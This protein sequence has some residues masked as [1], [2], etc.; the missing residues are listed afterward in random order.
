M[1]TM[2]ADAECMAGWL[3]CLMTVWTAMQ[4][5]IYLTRQHAD[6]LQQTFPSL[7]FLAQVQ[8]HNTNSFNPIIT[9]RATAIDPTGRHNK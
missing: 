8:L 9:N 7:P 4:N 1:V 5:N 6:D 2:A 3:A